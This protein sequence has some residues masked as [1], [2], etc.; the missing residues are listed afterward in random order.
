MT[1]VNAFKSDFDD[2]V[3]SAHDAVNKLEQAGKD[4]IARLEEDLNGDSAESVP[5]EATAEVPE[6]ST[7][8]ETKAS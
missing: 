7:K 6:A 1:H 8:D 3:K 2:A 5:A 4:L